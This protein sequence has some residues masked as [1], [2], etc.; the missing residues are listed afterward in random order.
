MSG[1]FRMLCESA[2]TRRERKAPDMT[3]ANARLGPAGRRELVR[4]MIE[5]KWPE[6]RAAE[7]LS[8]SSTTAH[9]WKRRWLT[10]TVEERRSGAWARD[11]SSRPR[12]S[13]RR[14]APEIEIAVLAARERT[15][16]GPRLL[17]GETGVA[18]STGHAI[19]KRHGRSRAPR[20]A[21]EQFKRYEWPCPGDLLHMDVKRYPRF[22]RP[23]HAVT[24]D[25]TRTW[26]DKRDALGHDYFHAV[27]DDH[28]RLAYAEVFPSESGC[29]AAT[30]L[31]HA[32]AWFEG[33]GIRC[34]RLLTDNAK[35]YA[36]S[37]RFKDVCQDRGIQQS[38]TRPYTP[39]TNGKAER[40]IQTL[41][42]RW[43]YRYVFKTSA[44]RAASLRPWLT[45]YNH[46]RPH[47][48]LGKKAPMARL[49]EARQQ[50]A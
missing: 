34:K 1:P 12:R 4:L 40:F 8:V 48:A 17:A 11:R 41:K 9:R 50:A 21:R 5:M 33:L 39:R 42:R 13:P 25:R 6:R 24:G 20:A 10:A 36:E 29:H 30:F 3:H 44:T 16:W 27:V 49:R 22:R 31:R 32:L 7:C 2:K 46:R 14:T 18:H 38:F 26:I 35:C 47:R 28:T 43:A 23:G 37:K 15:G 45:H 19:L